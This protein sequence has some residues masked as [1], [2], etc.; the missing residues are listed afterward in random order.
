MEKNIALESLVELTNNNLGYVPSTPT[1]FNALSLLIQKKTGR[2]I[3]LSSIKRIWGYVRYEGFPSL[4]TLNNLAQYN[5]FKDW[6][7]FMTTHSA[8][9]S[10]EDSEFIDE[11]IVNTDSLKPGDRLLLKWGDGK[12]CEIECVS[13]M[14]FRVVS[15]HNIKLQPGDVG[16]IHT[17]CVGHPIYVSDI[18]RHDGLLIPAYIGAK[19]GGITSIALMPSIRKIGL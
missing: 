15:S 7:S 18:R 19:R 17:L 9:N 6:E 11:S 5:G 4:T 1:E 10:E 2:S 14:T 16:T 8:R 12:A 13:S 3:S